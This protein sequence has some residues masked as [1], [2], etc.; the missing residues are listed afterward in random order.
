MAER[1]ADENCGVE[2]WVR[3]ALPQN[4]S[5]SSMLAIDVDVDGWVC[6]IVKGFVG[7]GYEQPRVWTTC[8]AEYL[9]RSKDRFSPLPN[10]VYGIVVRGNPTPRRHPSVL[11]LEKSEWLETSLWSVAQKGEEG[12]LY[13][14]GDF[15][16][17]AWGIQ[18]FGMSRFDALDSPLLREPDKFMTESTHIPEFAG[19]GWYM[20][21]Y[22]RRF[23]DYEEPNL[24][25]LGRE[26]P[27]I[28][29]HRE[30]LG[31]RPLVWCND[32]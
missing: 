8:V 13:V 12:A 28:E 19:R 9:L 2:D 5:L 21:D 31:L 26:D 32:C 3:L 15:Y 6:I 10:E 29:P 1:I 30:M 22:G 20:L 16:T 4:S 17:H 27:K 24:V 25:R 18:A 14:G 23:T 7:S 11:G